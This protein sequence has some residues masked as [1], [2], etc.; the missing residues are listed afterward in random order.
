MAGKTHEPSKVKVYT[1]KEL[2]EATG[3]P[4]TTIHFYLRNGLLPRPQKTSASRSLY[5]EE[6]L[7]ILQKITELKNAGLSLSEIEDHVRELV[8]AANRSKVDVVGLEHER[9]RNRILAVAAK[10]FG[11]KGYQKTHIN[12]IIRKAH[13]TPSLLYSY[14]SSKRILLL[15]C[16]RVLMNSSLEFVDSKQATMNDAARR[17]LWLI[18]GHA[19]VFKLGSSALSLAHIEGSQND[20]ELHKPLQRLFDSIIEHYMRE[21]R[22]A[23]R[24]GGQAGLVPDELI[25]HSLFGAYQQTMFRLQVDKKYSRR[26]TMLTH[27]WLFL[28]VQAA[29]SGEIDIDSRL[30][31]YEDFVNE[32]SND[33]P[34]LPPQLQD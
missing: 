16:V 28:A 27:L 2:R 14:F 29:K 17:V 32:L 9:I 15:E 23:A 10:E 7:N 26:D 31:Q 11:S 4:S 8:N 30:R 6:H 25:A 3:A 20:K 34:P 22:E 24:P 19:N 5:T 18:F 1:V 13:L 12:S 33:L 21:L